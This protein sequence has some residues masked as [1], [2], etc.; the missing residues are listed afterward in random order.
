MIGA[1]LLPARTVIRVIDGIAAILE[2][3]VDGLGVHIDALGSLAGRLGR[4]G[5]RRREPELG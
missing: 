3:K 2:A 4:F 1:L 5:A